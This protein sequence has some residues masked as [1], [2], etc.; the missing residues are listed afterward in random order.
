MLRV[1]R[2]E[3]Y[4]LDS[5]YLIKNHHSILFISINIKH[6]HRL[7]YY[8]MDIPILDTLGRPPGA[9]ELWT[10]LR[11]ES[12]AKLRKEEANI[13]NELKVFLMN[14]PCMI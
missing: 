12:N 8:K 13:P 6:E 4:F 2:I 10:T 7:H 14:F 3:L 11:N 5:K 9:N 1:G